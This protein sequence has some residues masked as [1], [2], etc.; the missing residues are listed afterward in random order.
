MSNSTQSLKIL[1]IEDNRDFALIFCSLMEDMGHKC[2][3]AFDGVEGLTKAKEMKPD[4]IFCDIGLPKM[5]G[6]DVAQNLKTEKSLSI[7]IVVALTGYAG[8]QDI[9][10]SAESGFDYHL[11]KPV[12]MCD[13]EMIL[14]KAQD[15]KNNP[16]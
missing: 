2:V 11:T 5:N 13:I 12:G 4:V 3:S 16:V 10:K 8:K 6:F 15:R 9:N 1:I 7:T 14:K